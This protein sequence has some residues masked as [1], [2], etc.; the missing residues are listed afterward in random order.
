MIM[1]HITAPQSIT[2]DTL[3]LQVIE[4]YPQTIA[5]FND[6]NMA[7]PGCHVSPF[8]TIADSAREYGLRSD[9]LL[10]ALNDAL[11]SNPV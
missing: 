6:L 5:V 4:S 11:A 1:N 2:P 8:H 9:E 7:C 3:V 10:Q